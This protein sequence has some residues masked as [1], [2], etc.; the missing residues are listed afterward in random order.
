MHQVVKTSALDDIYFEMLQ[1]QIVAEG[2]GTQR[3]NRKWKPS[4]Q[5]SCKWKNEYHK[6]F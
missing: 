5:A 1:G 2:Y 4:H 3:G 6:Y